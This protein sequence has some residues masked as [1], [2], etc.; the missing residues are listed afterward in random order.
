MILKLVCRMSGHSIDRKRVWHDTLNY[1]TTCARCHAQLLRGGTG[2][3]EFDAERDA[4]DH[5]AAHPRERE[6]E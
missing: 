3:R 4:D 1:R 2:W 6:T 5:R